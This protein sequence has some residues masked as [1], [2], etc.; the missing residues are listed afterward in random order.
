MKYAGKLSENLS[1]Y[2]AIIIL[3]LD[4]LKHRENQK[5]RQFAS[6]Y[7][8]S[9]TIWKPG[10]G[11]SLLCAISVRFLS[12]VSKNWTIAS[13][14]LINTIVLVISKFENWTQC[15]RSTHTQKGRI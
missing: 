5:L 4:A 14:I 15:V 2:N 13:G 11:L 3:I 9:W 8:K 7:I 10:S 1:M 12:N 6:E